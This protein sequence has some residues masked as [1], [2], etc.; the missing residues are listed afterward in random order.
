MIHDYDGVWIWRDLE[1]LGRYGGRGDLLVMI[2]I[3]FGEMGVQML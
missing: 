1:G 3:G 2:G